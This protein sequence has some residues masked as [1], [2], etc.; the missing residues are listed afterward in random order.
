MEM[1]AVDAEKYTKLTP[2]EHILQLPD[3]Y[4]G[5]ATPEAQNAW[6]LSEE[7]D[8]DGGGDGDGTART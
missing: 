5:S 7:R 1:E 4:I 6:V 3:T 8:G 2:I